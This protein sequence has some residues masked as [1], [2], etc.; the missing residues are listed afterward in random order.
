M[1]TKIEKKTIIKIVG[2]NLTLGLLLFGIVYINK[3]FFRPAFNETHLAQILT[4]SFP[5]FIAA[6]LISLCVV[7]PVLIRRPRLGRLIVYLGSLCIM[8]VL[9]IDEFESMSAS[10]QY[11]IYDIVGSILGSL[12][13]VLTYEYLHYRQFRIEKNDIGERGFKTTVN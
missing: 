10:K 8:T 11:D 12:F 5:T 4:G 1:N 9:I 2:I 13:A 6:F 7:N 3:T